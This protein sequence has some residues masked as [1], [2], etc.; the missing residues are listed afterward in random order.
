LH[1]VTERSINNANI[2]LNLS[3]GLLRQKIQG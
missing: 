2:Q 3:D 1:L